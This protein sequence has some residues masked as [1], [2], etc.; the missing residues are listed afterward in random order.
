MYLVRN[1]ERPGLRL[2]GRPVF[3]ERKNG[4]QSEYPNEYR[5]PHTIPPGRVAR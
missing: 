4:T 2:D 1:L 5:L 3:G